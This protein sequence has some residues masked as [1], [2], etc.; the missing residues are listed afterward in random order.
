MSKKTFYILSLVM[1]ICALF[2]HGIAHNKQLEIIRVHAQMRNLNDPEKQQLRIH[3][4]GL[5]VTSRMLW[6]IG[7]GFALGGVVCLVAARLRKESGWFSLPILF[8]FL[9][10]IMMMIL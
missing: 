4:D 3:A 7:I 10:L 2:S 9:D 8:L 6:R 5:K 1:S